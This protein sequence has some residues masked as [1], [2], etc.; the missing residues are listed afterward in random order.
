MSVQGFRQPPPTPRPRGTASCLQ[1]GSRV[2]IQTESRSFGA[3]ARTLALGK[4]QTESLGLCSGP[5][6]LDSAPPASVWSK[7]AGETMTG[8]L[9]WWS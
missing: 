3:T 2:G 8:F 7:S 4:D 9:S 1:R 6:A 5:Y